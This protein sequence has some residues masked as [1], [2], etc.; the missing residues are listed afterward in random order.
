MSKKDY[1]FTT[2]IFGAPARPE[3]IFAEWPSAEAL[4]ETSK[5]KILRTKITRIEWEIG[6]NA[7][8][9]LAFQAREAK[10]MRRGKV[11]ISKYTAGS[12]FPNVPAAIPGR[13]I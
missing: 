11:V 4:A 9:M 2:P 1:Y 10:K 8:W 7:I 5:E 12:A 3:N 6:H 13:K